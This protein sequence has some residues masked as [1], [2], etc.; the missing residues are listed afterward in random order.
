VKRLQLVAGAALVLTSALAIAQN[1]PE[2]LLPP[3]FERP[4]G[5]PNPAPAPQGGSTSIPVVQ[6]VPGA[7]GSAA[8]NPAALPKNIPSL[9]ELEKM[10][11]EELDKLLGLRPKSDMPAAAR[12]SMRQ[13]GVLAES[14]GGFASG[15]FNAQDPALVKAILAGNRGQMVSRWG[16]IL[17]RRALAS[18]LSAPSAMNPAD[19]V[20]QR[21]AL[22]VRMGE[23]EAARALVQDV[24]AGNFTPDLTQA[25]IDAYVATA[26]LTGMCPAVTVHGGVRKD[27]EWQVA[28]SICGA[29][30][31][32]GTYAMS[33]LDRAVAKG[34]WPKVDLL[35]AQKYAGAAG[36]ER[37]DVKIEWDDVE[38]MNPWR[39]ALTIATG[40]EPPAGLMKGA[41]WRYDTITATAPMLGLP[42]RAAAAD[43]ASAVGVLSS[44]AM[45]DLYGQ[46]FAQQD[47]TG[48]W[49]TRAEQLREAYVADGDSARMAAITALWDDS[50][51]PQQRYGR[52]VLTAY[53]AARLSPSSGMS[54]Q[55]PDLIASMLAAGLDRNAMRWANVAET[56]TQAWALLTL[57]APSRS[58]PVDSGAL[59]SFYGDDDSTDA[60]KSA[61][62]LAGLA[63]LGRV[64]QGTAREFAGKLGVDLYGQSKWTKAIESAAVANNAAMV[65]V[66]AG[67]GMQGDS[68][69]K[70][71]PRYLYHIVSALNRVGLGAEARMIAAEAV[72]RG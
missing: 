18:R 5:R 49:Q 22:L 9:E 32:D 53:A 51:G 52:Q 12:R 2:S 15:S 26:D 33:Q 8:A 27:P 66:L 63:G 67:L 42:T 59:G 28:R 43:R 37:R 3:G 30:S 24:D 11:P 65:A 44:A 64:D 69:D 56:G 41:S 7:G 1:S 23:G 29:F 13:V 31:G 10:S 34:A 4:K 48:P 47:I 55:A 19:F 20:A 17:L 38:S 68:W 58:A 62:L 16:H 54:Q 57:A 6:A 46:I 50:E 25:A 60:R 71:T 61:F 35:L 36:K 72:A 21:A 14:E 45:V 39:Y 40:L 70:M